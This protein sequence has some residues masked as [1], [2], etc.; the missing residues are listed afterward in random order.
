MPTGNDGRN[1]VA[2]FVE[3]TR[4]AGFSD[5]RTREVEKPW[6]M[7]AGTDL[8]T[9]FET[10]TVR[11]ASL[12]KGQKPEA[13]AAIRRQVAGVTTSCSADGVTLLQTKATIVSASKGSA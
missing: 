10:S 5:I 11:M 1:S 12:I 6:R 4:R 7:P 9:L 8:V 2:D 3:L 13:L